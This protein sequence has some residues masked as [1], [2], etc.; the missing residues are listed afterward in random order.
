[1]VAKWCVC[2]LVVVL[3]L[4]ASPARAQVTKRRAVCNATS[5][6]DC[7]VQIGSQMR[8]NIGEFLRGSELIQP[9]ISWLT[10]SH[11]STRL[12]L[13]LAA[14]E[15]QYPELVDEV[16]GLAHG[17][18]QEFRTLF[19]LNLIN[20]LGPEI[21]NHTDQF[22]YVTRGCSDYHV[23]AGGQQA[24]GH[25]EDG[26]IT[27]EANTTYMVQSRIRLPGKDAE[28]YLA[29]TYPGRLSGW[30]WGFNGHGI[31]QSVNALWDTP[32]S[33]SFLGVSFVSRSVLGS[34]SLV[35]AVTRASVRGQAGG[36]HFN[37]GSIHAACTSNDPCQLSLEVAPGRAPSSFGLEG[38]PGGRFAHFNQYLHYDMPYTGPYN[39]SLQSSV[40]RLARAAEYS[41]RPGLAPQ[42]G[43]GILRFLSDRV[44]PEYPVWRGPAGTNADRVMTFSTSLFDLRGK[45]LEVFTRQPVQ[46]G[47]VVTTPDVVLDLR[48]P[49]HWP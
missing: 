7:G 38:I 12:D 5:H 2:V 33:N 18:G 11:G 42:D 28:T 30:A 36:E 32:Q 45:T 43:K 17:A 41:W 1:M 3:S 46:H 22:P 14:H 39:I 8:T 37:L 19:A 20:E 26:D 4:L 31:V 44:D 49:M 21:Q 40:H 23:M 34:T 48:D 16:R 10:S 9:M 35:D 13:Y 47:G 15:S 29:F 25:N 27:V 6:Y 24:W